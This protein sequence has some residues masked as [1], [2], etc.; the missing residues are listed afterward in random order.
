LVLQPRGARRATADRTRRPQKSIRDTWISNNEQTRT[1]TAV[2]AIH[3]RAHSDPSQSDSKPLPALPCRARSELRNADRLR[4]C[5]T[6]LSWRLVYLHTLHAWRA[7]VVTAAFGVVFA[8]VAGYRRG[9]AAPPA[10]A[11][12]AGSSLQ[13]RGSSAKPELPLTQQPHRESLALDRRDSRR[14]ATL[15][16]QALAA[17]RP[18]PLA[19]SPPLPR[20][21]LRQAAV[22]A[23]SLLRP[24]QVPS[25]LQHPH[26]LPP[27]IP[28]TPCHPPPP[29]RRLEP[30]PSQP[31][32]VQCALLAAL[33]PRARGVAP[34]VLDRLRCPG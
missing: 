29:I 2:H 20:G 7:V 18:P 21:A 1:R 9:S 10:T 4:L 33:Q 28:R 13:I 24:T 8:G 12:V 22:C 31:A 16:A 19:A 6:I 30:T 25:L 15:R 32:A 26:R 11:R 3:A 34:T 5:Q 23:S 17:S 27:L 14:R